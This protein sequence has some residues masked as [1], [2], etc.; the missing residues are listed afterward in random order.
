[1]SALVAWLRRTVPWPSSRL[2][3]LDLLAVAGVLGGAAGLY[4]FGNRL[5]PGQQILLW[6]LLLA[7]AAFVGRL[8]GPVLFYDLVR[9]ARRFRYYVI[10]VLYC[11]FLLAMLC[12]MYFTYAAG[13]DLSSLRPD[14]A[15][16]F[17]SSFFYTFMVVQFLV[18]TVVTPA[19]VAGALAEEKERK[20]LEF[21]L[22]TDLLNREIV[23]SKLAARLLNLL[24]LVLTG[25]PVLAGLQFLGGVDPLLVL[26][27][28]AA[29]LLTVASLAGLSILASALCR[30][31]RDAIV[32]TYLMT[33]AYL[34][35]SGL[36]WLLVVPTF[37]WA[38]FPSTPAWTSPVTVQDLVH[39]LNAGN[40]VAVLFRL[41][42]DLAPPNNQSIDEVVPA[43]L[44]AYALF[45][46]AVAVL[47]PLWAVLRL[48][49][50]A[51]KETNEPAPLG[52]SYVWLLI[53]LL[54]LPVGV[55]VI[56]FGLLRQIGRPTPLAR[57]GKKPRL[58]NQPMI[59]K[60]VFADH[61]MRIHGVG[62]AVVLLLV[63]AS[64]APAVIIG[65]MFLEG[66]LDAPLRFF[67]NRP[68]PWEALA[69]NTQ[70]WVVRVTGT[71]VAC[72][73]L[74]AVAV[75]ASSSISI[76]RDR[77]TIDGLL[78]TPLDSDNILF[79]KWLGAVVSVRRG[80]LWLGALWGFGVLTGGLHPLG[81]A[82]LVVS[83]FVYAAF[84]AGLGTWFSTVSR[85]TLRATMWTLL[86][87]VAAA[88]GHWMIWM[89]CIPVM[90]VRAGPMPDVLSWVVKYQAGLT[91]L[92]N[93][94][95]FASFRQG[96][97]RDNIGRPEE[98]WE[99]AGFGV[100]GTATWALLAGG[101]WLATS[102]RFRQAA[103][104]AAF[105]P[106]RVVRPSRRPAVAA[107]APAPAT[108][109]EA[110]RDA[111]PAGAEPAGGSEEERIQEPR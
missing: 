59:W 7:V 10:R 36:S 22:A 54:L 99:L 85:T 12:W 14:E 109:G 19:Y 6:G 68:D 84:V 32:L 105:A 67:G 25:L 91:P 52:L 4:Q 42:A 103:G 48:R 74:V 72:M 18:V 46:G 108:D 1:M 86:C 87:T 64:L 80:W 51:M 21:L 29:T 69:E 71:C 60:E 96:D 27:G 16:R 111:L 100:M 37:G 35:L 79:G 95:V 24:L 65:Y 73:L 97:F 17:A 23:L 8:F 34:G 102:Y 47:G 81:L 33:F 83:W 30:R 77:Q 70:L 11:L 104:R 41:S 38:T 13:A 110:I 58:G 56:P 28:F 82:L 44:R 2:G 15:A 106:E 93:M 88:V 26:A 50:I 40:I 49:A 75:R 57:A 53:F 63:L 43:Y 107:A 94:G 62:K 78:T 5:P 3:W 89:C 92:F 45:H 9:A 39:W 98:V 20:T 31:A 61:G 76:E 55:I 66:T 101:L 90:I